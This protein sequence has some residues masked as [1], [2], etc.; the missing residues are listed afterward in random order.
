MSNELRRL[1]R[2]LLKRAADAQVVATIPGAPG[3]PVPGKPTEPLAAKEREVRLPL[4]PEEA[5]ALTAS[6]QQVAI[7]QLQVDAQLRI[8]L[9]GHHIRV[10]RVTQILDTQPRQLVV[11][12]P[13]RA[14][15]NGKER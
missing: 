13:V 7:A 6:Q 11:F 9:A 8:V 14:R 4:T 12:V 3:Q 5:E 2:A 1:K 10:G 15:K